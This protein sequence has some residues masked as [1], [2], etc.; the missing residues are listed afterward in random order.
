M[1]RRALCAKVGRSGRVVG[2]VEVVISPSMDRI[3]GQLTE[4][5]CDYSD[6]R[7]LQDKR[8]PGQSPGSLIVWGDQWG[9]NPR[10]SEPQSD[11]IPLHHG[12]HSTI[13]QK[14]SIERLPMPE[15][16]LEL[17]VGGVRV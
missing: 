9:S 16:I 2:A 5:A 8:L 1:S 12:H 6:E 14:C 10:S 11:V 13:E 4:P 7:G 3:S 15:A 17:A